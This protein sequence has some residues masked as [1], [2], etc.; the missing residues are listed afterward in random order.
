MGKFGHEHI[1]LSYTT[2]IIQTPKSDP[3]VM[4]A[5]SKVMPSTEGRKFVTLPLP[6]IHSTPVNQALPYHLDVI[7]GKSFVYIGFFSS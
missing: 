7:V 3:W 5:Q 4:V 1:P 6:P 2:F